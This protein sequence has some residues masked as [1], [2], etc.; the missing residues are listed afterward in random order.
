MTQKASARAVS[1]S[2]QCF[3]TQRKRDSQN[4]SYVD[5]ILQCEEHHPQWVLATRSH[6]LSA[7]LQGDLAVYASLNVQ[8]ETKVVAGRIMAA[9]SWQCSTV[10]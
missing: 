7:S 8:K 5:Q 10:M 2:L 1:G 6:D 9:S 3:Q 4:Q